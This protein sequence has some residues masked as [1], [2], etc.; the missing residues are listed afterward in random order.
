M[1]K[2]LLLLAT[3]L[4]GCVTDSQP[5]FEIFVRRSAPAE[6]MDA[7]L[8]TRV[9]L[10][11]DDGYS[12][13]SLSSAASFAMLQTHLSDVENL[14]ACIKVMRR[15]TDDNCDHKPFEF[16]IDNDNPTYTTVLAETC[17]P[18]ILDANGMF[19]V[20]TGTTSTGLAVTVDI[21]PM[22]GGL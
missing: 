8:E 11:T 9:E 2:T 19:E 16:C 14:R 13:E 22:P 1:L 3:V 6:L 15:D 21:H 10:V 12:V 17:T 5:N 18:V 4:T 7:P 20:T